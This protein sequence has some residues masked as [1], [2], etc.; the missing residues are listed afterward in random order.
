[1]SEFQARVDVALGNPQIARQIAD[2]TASREQIERQV[3]NR[4]VEVIL[5]DQAAKDLDVTVSDS[6]VDARL[7]KEIADRFGGQEQ[8]QQV[9]TE[10]GLSD[11]DIRTQLRALMLGE[12][13]QS[14]VSER[15]TA[16]DVAD[17]DVQAAYRQQFTGRAPVARHILLKTEAEAEDVKAQLKH[18]ADFAALA[19]ERSA[20]PSN[21]KIGGLVG[22]VVPG[23]FVAEFE[24][25]VVQAHDNAIIGPVKTQ[26]GFHIIQRLATPPLH[27][28]VDASLREKLL[29]AR[30]AQAFQAFVLQERRKS[31]VQLSPRF[32]KWDPE[33]GQI[34]PPQPQGTSPSNPQSG[35][36][37]PPAG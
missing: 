22:E 32:G 17:A 29:E 24:R 28:I 21:A 9:L 3:L 10:Q 12:R 15:V 19:R 37:Q 25:A 8:Y 11:K 20:D 2:G 16:S 23:Q 26:Y 1:M 18:G 30:Q 13:I 5:L 27:S 31:S 6:E 34:V 7:R 14:K 36:G 35:A 33:T 4:M